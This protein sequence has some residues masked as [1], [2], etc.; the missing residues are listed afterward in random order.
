MHLIEIFLPLNA[1]DGTPQ[2]VELFRHAREQLADQFGGVT[3]FSRNP[4]R[5]ISQPGGNV[6]SEDERKSTTAHWRP[7][8][9]ACNQYSKFARK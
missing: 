9:P 6:I 8:E 4:A 1:N 7:Y 5:G 2:P 3:A